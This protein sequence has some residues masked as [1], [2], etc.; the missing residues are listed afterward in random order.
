M[1]DLYIYYQVREHDAAVLAPRLLSMQARLG[2]AH[3][4]GVALKRRPETRD[5]LQ[6]WMEIYT[7]TND[8]FGAALD[9]ALQDAGVSAMIV[10]T[11]HPEVFM[12]LKSCV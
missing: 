9:A 11:R 7:A 8:G 3:Q 2:A 4:V 5:G 6:T 12:D 10:G 1:V